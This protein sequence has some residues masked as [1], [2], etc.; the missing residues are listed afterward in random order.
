MRVSAFLLILSIAGVA[1][2]CAQSLADVARQESERRQAVKDAGKTYT[3]KDLKPVPTP[4]PSDAATA[5]DADKAG[6]IRRPTRR[7]RK[8][9]LPP[10]GKATRSRRR[11]ATRPRSR[12]RPT[13]RSGWPAC[14]SS[15]SATRP[16]WTR[17]RAASTRSRPTSSTAT[18]RRSAGQIAERPAEGAGR[19]RP[20]EEDRRAGQA[21]HPRAR[22]GSASSRRSGRLAAL[23]RTASSRSADPA[24]RGQG[25][26]AR[27]A[28]PRARDAGPRRHRGAR[29]AGSRR[30]AALRRGPASCCR[31]CGSATATASASSARRRRSTPTCRSS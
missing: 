26:A 17:C 10:T 27:D 11:A 15:W 31:T 22:R 2:V 8:T 4:P 14:A 18:T 29:P 30:G 1:P 13:G 3:N 19:A 24:R 20:G 6:A 21:R 7:H 5:P 23:V 12:T 16:S 9:S 28:P 25:L